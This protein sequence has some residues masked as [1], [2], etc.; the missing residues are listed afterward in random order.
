MNKTLL[1]IM[2]C[3]L[4]V[5]SSFAETPKISNGMVVDD[6]GMT[7]Y[8]FDKD[9]VPGKSACVGACAA[10]W[11]AAV[12]DSYDKTS[13]D[14]GFIA[15]GEGKHQWTYKGRPL[16][17]FANDKQPGQMNGDGF[18]GIWHIVKP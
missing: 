14:W 4:P 3:A 11:P 17:R 15:A 5:A 18:K 10:L 8:A 2:A 1:C 13:G 6:D 9:T 7:L 16:Y 12:A